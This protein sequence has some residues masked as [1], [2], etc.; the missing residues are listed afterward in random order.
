MSPMPLVVA[1]VQ[2]L[3]HQYRANFGQF[4]CLPQQNLDNFMVRLPNSSTS[5]RT[6]NWTNKTCTCLYWQDNG[7]I[8]IHGYALAVAKGF[9]NNYDEFIAYAV[10]SCYLSATFCEVFKESFGLMVPDP[11]LLAQ[12]TVVVPVIRK[13]RREK[14]FKSASEG[15]RKKYPSGVHP[16]RSIETLTA[17]AEPEQ[18][19]L[20][21]SENEHWQP[22][23][24][25]ARL[26]DLRSAE[27]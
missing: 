13:T 3:L 2:R 23:I 25:V 6:V 5:L 24:D 1:P 20:L 9:I 7:I 4:V 12:D 15:G 27:A 8:C 11:E 16:P 10:D 17:A 26:E 21:S 18:Q 22:V 19:T 14:R